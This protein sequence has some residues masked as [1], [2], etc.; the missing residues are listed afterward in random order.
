M[1]SFF[2]RFKKK[3]IP[4]SSKG[5]SYFERENIIQ[6]TRDL[7]NILQILNEKI[8]S[9]TKKDITFHGVPLLKTSP[10]ELKNKFG[11]PMYIFNNSD[12]I[13]SHKIFFYKDSVDFY[14][15]LIQ[16]HFIDNNF[17]FASNKVSS[18]TA[19]SEEDKTKIVGRIK[20]K[21]FGEE[22]KEIKGLKVKL[23]DQNGSIFYT[24]DDVY[25]YLNYLLDNQTTKKLIK[26]YPDFESSITHPPGFKESLEEYI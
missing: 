19:L 2:K 6:D 25:Y 16:Y 15:F 9:E 24:V 23:R 26:L 10:R 8:F 1:P 22:A 14:K 4:I 21:Y 13:E 11:A 18:L 7:K 3:I 12:N 17:F 20:T 5:S